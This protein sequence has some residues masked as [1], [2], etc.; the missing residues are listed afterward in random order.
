MPLD[1]YL[2]NEVELVQASTTGEVVD[3]LESTVG[4]KLLKRDPES[5]IVVNFH[6]VSSFLSCLP[7]ASK[8]SFHALPH[9]FSQPFMSHFS[10]P[11]SP[12]VSCSLS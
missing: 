11:V 8:F 10:C 5:R 3:D 12:F 9:F 4:A 1:V 6:G 7:F 2:E